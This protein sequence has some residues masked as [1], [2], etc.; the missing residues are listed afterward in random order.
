MNRVQ[1]HSISNVS[2]ERIM[3]CVWE[4]SS[5]CMNAQCACTTKWASKLFHFY[6]NIFHSFAALFFQYLFFTNKILTL[7]PALDR[8][9]CE[10]LFIIFPCFFSFVQ[11]TLSICSGKIWIADTVETRLYEEIYIN[12]ALEVISHLII[13]IIIIIFLCFFFFIGMDLKQSEW[14]V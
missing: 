14:S 9:L 13:V 3:V 2:S 1:N 7:S 11:F 10:Y 12:G 4:V 6:A 8:R 5:V